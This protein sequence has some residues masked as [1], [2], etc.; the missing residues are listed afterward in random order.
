[1]KKPGIIVGKLHANIDEELGLQVMN[2]KPNEKITLK[3]KMCD[4]EGKVFESM[5]SFITNEHGSVSLSEAK[6]VEGSYDEIDPDGLFWSME[7]VQARHGSFFVKMNADP[8]K[9]DLSLEISGEILDQVQISR[10]FYTFLT[11]AY[12]GTEGVPK[13]LES[14]PLEYFEKATHWLKNHPAVNEQVSVM[15]FS[16]GGEL[17]LL[18]GAIY[19]EY[20]SVIAVSPSSYVT[21]GM[22]NDMFA[23]ISSWTHQGK[24]LDYMKFSYPPSMI[25]SMLHN[26]MLKRPASFLAIWDRTMR[27][28][29]KNRTGSDSCRKHTRACVDGLRKR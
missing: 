16:R 29:E 12:F 13:D 5:A 24:A 20:K 15:G 23:P 18:L 4:D 21:A 19:D 9:V 8:V 14:I 28:E 3:A 26:W 6:P 1:M 10:H 7:D 27:N 17:A 22:K 2:C 11:L 25:F